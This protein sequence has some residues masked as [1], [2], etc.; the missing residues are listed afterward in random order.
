MGIKALPKKK[1]KIT[2]CVFLQQVI[3]FHI[4]KAELYNFVLYYRLYKYL[5][6]HCSFTTELNVKAL[7]FLHRNIRCQKHLPML[8]SRLWFHR[9][10]FKSLLILGR[11][12]KDKPNF[13]PSWTTTDSVVYN[14]VSKNS[15]L[16]CSCPGLKTYEYFTQEEVPFNHFPFF[17]RHLKEVR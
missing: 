14:A 2:S 7:T 3:S 13:N 6:L 11:K 4:T 17:Q 8:G 16:P 9:P 15:K 12:I 1:L 5:V 10:L